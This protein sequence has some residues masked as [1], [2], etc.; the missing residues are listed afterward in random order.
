VYMPDCWAKDPRRRTRAGIPEDLAFATKPELAIAQAKRLMAAG[1]RVTWAAAD[2]VYGRCGEFRAALRALGL[3]YV[4]VIPCDYRVALA[5]NTVIRADQAIARAVFERRSCGNGTKGPRYGD[6][7]LIATAD[8][9]EFLLIRR[10]PDRDKNQY[11]FYLCWSPEGRP[12]TM[13]YFITIA[14]RRWPVEITF[15]TGKDALGWD[16]SQARTWDA[17]CR[18]TALTA[19]A[20]LRTA[21]IQA[22]LA[23]ALP[24]AP[25][26]SQDAPCTPDQ[27]TVNPADLQIYTG[28]APLPARGGQPCPP[29]IPPI[30]LSA[31]ETSRIERLARDWKADLISLARLAFQLRWSTW[32]RRHQARARWHH[33]AT[34]LAALAT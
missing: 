27:T 31:A 20:Q 1:L 6:W 11:A 14:G 32:R 28:G 12:A 22:A 23:S 29:R 21:A 30:T 34:R 8:P 13:T 10:F 9:R 26:V 4:V 33:Y 18:H 16:Q 2:E 5:R 19:L 3:A 7:A 15:K 17:I 24:A 25:A